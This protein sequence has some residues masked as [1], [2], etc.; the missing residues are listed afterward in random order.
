[1]SHIKIT[2]I[3]IGTA[4]LTLA[5]LCCPISWLAYLNPPTPVPPTLP[6]AA[7][8][9]PTLTEAA[10][11]TAAIPACTADLVRLLKDSETQSAPGQE[12]DTQYTLVTYTVSGTTLSNPIEHSPIPGSLKKYQADTATQQKIWNYVTKILPPDQLTRVSNFVI[13]T[14]GVNG[15]L[16]AVEQTSDPHNW[17]LELDI[18]DDRN[19]P[20]LSTT[21]IHELAHLISLDDT[22]FTTDYPVFN[23]P[24]NQQ[25]Y[26]RE[27][28]KC[29][30]YFDFEGCSKPDSYMNAFFNRFWPAIY[31]EWKA[32]NTETDQDLLDQKLDNFYQEYADQFVS[33]Y[34][35]TDPSEDLAESFM[36]FVFKPKP[37]ADT[38]ADQKVLFFYDYPELVSL[39]TQLLTNLCPLVKTP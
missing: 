13:Y 23:N 28:A 30:T 1:M 20:I 31:D 25:I 24:D 33:S 10:T 4:I 15:S 5:C 19:F 12:L 8:A 7:T 18:Q 22:Q 11:E 6:P 21:L 34:A 39:R 26:D 17:I 27:A 14:D 36:Y 29:S 9:E 3:L 38:I 35:A 32:I 37:S 2:G 16:G